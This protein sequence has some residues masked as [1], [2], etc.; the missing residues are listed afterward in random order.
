MRADKSS[1][2]SFYKVA[3]HNFLAWRCRHKQTG[4]MKFRRFQLRTAMTAARAIWEAHGSFSP[5]IQQSVAPCR[6]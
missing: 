5:P 2:T 1:P 3:L 6:Y 4:S